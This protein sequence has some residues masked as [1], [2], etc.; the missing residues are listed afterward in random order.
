MD[1]RINRFEVVFSVDERVAV[2]FQFALADRKNFLDLPLFSLD[3][4][5][6]YRW[7]IRS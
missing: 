3:G 2:G 6:L 5:R 7:H 4:R 1:S